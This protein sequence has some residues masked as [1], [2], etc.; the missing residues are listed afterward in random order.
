MPKNTIA[1]TENK[2]ETRQFPTAPE[3]AVIVL[4][5]GVVPLLGT[6]PPFPWVGVAVGT[7]AFPVGVGEGGL[8]DKLIV[9]I[10]T[11]L[12]E[13]LLYG[14]LVMTSAQLLIVIHFVE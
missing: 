10:G 1:T 7:T 3:T 14:Q 12:V 6:T 2:A 9:M 8:L 5:P 11:M 13:T 4:L